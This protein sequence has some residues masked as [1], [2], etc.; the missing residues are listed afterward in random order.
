MAFEPINMT[1]E[2]TK[3]FIDAEIKKWQAVAQAANIQLD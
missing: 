3:A 2:Q 1:P